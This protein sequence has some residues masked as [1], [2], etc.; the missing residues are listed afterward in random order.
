MHRLLNILALCLLSS[1]SGFAQINGRVVDSQTGEGLVGA[2]IITNTAYNTISNNEGYFSIPPEN[3]MPQNIRISYVGFSSETVDL[4]EIQSLIIIRLDP[5]PQSIDEVMVTVSGFSE[6]ILRSTGSVSALSQQNLQLHNNIVL[7]DAINQV[8]GLYMAGGGYNTNRLTIRGIGSRS[9]YSS[10]RIRAYLNDIPLTT[11]DGTTSIE[12]IDIAAISRIEVLKGPSSAV[13]GSGL[14][15]AVRMWTYQPVDDKFS[16]SLGSEFSSFGT[17]RSFIRSGYKS[18]E[19]DLSLFYSRSH[20]DGYRQNSDYTRNSLLL[21][22]N[23]FFYKGGLKFTLLYTDVDAGIPS[24]VNYQSFIEN[25]KLAAPNWLAINGFERYKKLMLGLTNQI[26]LKHG[27]SNKISVFATFTDPYESRPFNILDEKSVS[28]GIQEHFSITAGK[29]ELMG[30]GEIFLEAFNWKIFETISGTQGNLLANN[31]EKR[32]YLNGFALSRFRPNEKL[33]AELGLNLNVLSYS[34]G[35]Y[36]TGDSVDF[37]GNYFYKPVLSPR[38]GINYK[39]GNAINLH[40]SL[41]HGFSAPSL[42]ET[43]LPD[44]QINTLLKPETG[45]NFDGGIRGKTFDGRLDFDIALY[46][47]ALDNLLV[48]KRIS[49]EIFSG[50]NAG[51]TNHTGLECMFR[52]SILSPGIKE[53]TE[54]IYS[55]SLAVSRNRFKDFSDDNTDFSGKDLPGIPSSVIYN[56]LRLKILKNIEISAINKFTGRQFMNDSNTEVNKNYTTTDLRLSARKI[57]GV[58]Q[59]KLQVYGGV[60]NVFN[61]TY[62]GM[63]LVNAPS[64]GVNPPRYYYPALPRNFTVGL[65]IEVN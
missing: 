34:L 21:N 46:H 5:E 49:E 27:M 61:E 13:Y 36:F 35:D 28:G 32:F 59:H 43:L 17:T 38:M 60:K 25:P 8:A 12:D 56:E 63:I 14:G 48:T 65:V 16:M 53:H 15:G 57:F 29:F 18:D 2:A 1:L 20:S 7:N 37:S 31:H 4:K 64:A 45:W 10:N 41:G 26:S 42:E 22:A 44:G 11:G 50:I 52:L 30:G 62:A 54:L 55:T 3:G 24:S 23:R 40:A 58:K 47:I 33:T 6:N 9:P 39:V 19:G 51:K